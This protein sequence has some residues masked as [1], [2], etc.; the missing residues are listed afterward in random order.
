VKVIDDSRFIHTELEISRNLVHLLGMLKFRACLTYTQFKNLVVSHTN[1]PVSKIGTANKKLC[2][3]Y[4]GILSDLGVRPKRKK[5][6]S[7]KSTN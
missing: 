2:A 1:A 4:L 5:Q 6:V 3:F 7:Y